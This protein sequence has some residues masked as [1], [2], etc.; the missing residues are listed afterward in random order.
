[1]LNNLTNVDTQTPI[2]GN[3]TFIS[4]SLLAL[5]VTSL[6]NNTNDISYLKLTSEQLKLVKGIK[7][8]G[9][10]K[11]VYLYD[12]K[13]SIIL[14][15]GKP[16]SSGTIAGN[17]IGV[18]GHYLLSVVN[19]NKY[20]LDRYLAS[21]DISMFPKGKIEVQ[22]RYKKVYAYDSQWNMIN[23]GTPFNTI[24]EASKDL[25][26]PHSTISVSIKKDKLCQGKYYFRYSPKA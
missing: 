16:F 7:K 20:I 8:I 11:M 18:S 19:K 5:I 4:N 10:R 15:N 3:L 22:P 25:A 9:N 6:N 24:S 26:I 14:N 23:G 12:T 13:T 21:T 17:A 2:N 1:M